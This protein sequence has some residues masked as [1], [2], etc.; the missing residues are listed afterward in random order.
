MKSLKMVLVGNT[1]VGKSCLI[2]NYLYN[3]FSE[4]YEPTV[5]DVFKGIKNVNKTQYEIEIQDT[6][7]DELLGI[8]RKVQYKDADV[9]VI[10]V[11]AND[12]NSLDSVAT[13]KAE[14][15]EIE[16]GKPIALYLTKRDL[17]EIAED[18]VTYDMIKEKK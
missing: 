11:G 14:I 8:N 13:W 18:P 4:D 3:S 6:S 2:T 9:F 17:A 16:V 7:G 5:L 12:R 1:A 15:E 10:C